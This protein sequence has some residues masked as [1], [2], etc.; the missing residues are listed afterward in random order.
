MSKLK[1]AFT[2]ALLVALVPVLSSCSPGKLD[3]S[4]V[5]N[6]IDIRSADDFAESHIVGAINIDD[7]QGDLVALASPLI[8]T[9]KYFLYGNDDAS[10]ADAISRLAQRGY[11]DLTNLGDFANA[12]RILPLGVSK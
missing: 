8:K 6:I 1:L 2:A 5:T 10:V 11:T 9:G 4:N 3:I 7:S 12:Q